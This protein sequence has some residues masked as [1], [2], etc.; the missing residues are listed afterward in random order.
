MNWMNISEI[1]S[2]LFHQTDTT[3]IKAQ[4]NPVKKYLILDFAIQE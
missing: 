4:V 3:W 1:I 2:K